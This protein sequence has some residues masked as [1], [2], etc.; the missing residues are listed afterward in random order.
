MKQAAQQ[1]LTDADWAVLGSSSNAAQIGGILIRIR[2]QFLDA[3]AFTDAQSKLATGGLDETEL[4]D[5][6]G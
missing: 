3:A 5:A 2:A 6:F 1:L 4:E